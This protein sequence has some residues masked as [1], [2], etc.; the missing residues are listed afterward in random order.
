MPYYKI[1]Y[2]LLQTLFLICT[3]A[4]YIHLRE[5]RHVDYSTYKNDVAAKNAVVDTR[6]WWA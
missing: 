1:A 6:M 4:N 5:S 3:T 2:L